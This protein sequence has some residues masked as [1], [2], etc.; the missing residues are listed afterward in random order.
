MERRVEVVHHLEPSS[1]AQVVD[2]A[3]DRNALQPRP[4]WPG[5]VVA[6]KRAERLLD[7]LLRGVGQAYGQ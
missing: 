5:L 6:V 1:L 4:E 7:R 3:V 2:G